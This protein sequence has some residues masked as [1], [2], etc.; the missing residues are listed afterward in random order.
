MISKLAGN[1]LKIFL[2]KNRLPYYGRRYPIV[3]LFAPT[4]GF[5]HFLKRI[6]PDWMVSFLGVGGKVRSL[7]GFL[8]CVKLRDSHLLFS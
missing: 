8:G 4:V 5:I 6:V 7:G 3:L 2:R 1:L